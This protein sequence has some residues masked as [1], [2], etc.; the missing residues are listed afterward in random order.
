[1]IDSAESKS[2]STVSRSLTDSYIDLRWA[3]QTCRTIS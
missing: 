3:I 2:L 1:M